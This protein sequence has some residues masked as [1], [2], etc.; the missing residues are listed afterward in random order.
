MPVDEGLARAGEIAVLTRDGVKQVRVGI[1][2]D[3]I[4]DMGPAELPGTDRKVAV[5]DRSW[6]A[7]ES[8]SSV[9]RS[10]PTS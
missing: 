8:W 6:P 9:W 2:G 3:V 4:V 1:E 10:V 7:N 5:A